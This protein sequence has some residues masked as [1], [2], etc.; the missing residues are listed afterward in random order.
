MVVTEL[1]SCSPVVRW[2][3]EVPEPAQESELVLVLVLEPALEPLIRA[4]SLN[5]SVVELV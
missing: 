1:A 5:R 2:L 4:S 3:A